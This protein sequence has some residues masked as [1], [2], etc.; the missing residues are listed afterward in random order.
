M[1]IKINIHP[2][3]NQSIISYFH[4][5]FTK[6]G[7]SEN[8]KK[9]YSLHEPIDWQHNVCDGSANSPHD[10]HEAVGIYTI[11]ILII[12]KMAFAL[13]PNMIE[14]PSMPKSIAS[15]NLKLNRHKIIRIIN[16]VN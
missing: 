7:F 16:F 6:H 11:N 10:K 12:L 13:T 8:C 2:S 3:R 14:N 1:Y 9:S 4:F 15:R 5:I